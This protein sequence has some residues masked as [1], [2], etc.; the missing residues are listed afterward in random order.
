MELRRGHL[1][2]PDVRLSPKERP[3]KIK[4]QEMIMQQQFY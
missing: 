1:T 2:D 4:G 3:P